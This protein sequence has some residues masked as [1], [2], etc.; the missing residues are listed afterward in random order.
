MNNNYFKI[1]CRYLLRNKF[2]SFIKITGLSIG[3][4]ACMLIFLYSKDEISYDRFHEKKANLYRVSQTFQ[5]GKNS[6]QKLGITTEPLG[7]AFKKDIPEISNYIRTSGALVTLKKSTEV[8]TEHP[9]FVD[10]D[11]LSVFTF[12]LLKGDAN[13]ALK[14]INSVVLTS[15]SAKKYFGSSDVIGKTLQVKYQNEFDNFTVTGLAEDPPQNST[16]RFDLLL[17]FA[18]KKKFENTEEWFGGNLNTFLLLLPTTKVLIVEK[19][20]QAL[21]DQHTKEELGS[22]KQQQGM[23]VKITLGLQPLADIHL[24]TQLGQALDDVSNPLYSYVLIGIAVFILIIACINFINLAIAQSLKRSK[25]IGIRKVVGSSRKQLIWQFLI[26]SFVVSSVAFLIAIPL[27]QLILPFFNEL[28]NKKLS[29][30]YLSDSYLYVG[31]FLLLLI[32]SFIA[33]FYP[34]L[35]LSGFQP[36]KVLNN[37]QKLLGKGYYAKGLI[38]LQFALAIF[39]IIATIAINSQVNFLLHE[40]LGYESKNLVRINLPNNKASDKLPEIFKHELAN[41]NTILGVA[42]RNW[43]ESIQFPLTVEGKQI[44]IDYN[45]I[46]PQFFSTFK[47]PIIAGR[48]FSSDFPSDPPHAVIV[49]EN[50]VNE[51]GWNINQAVGKLIGED[52]KTVVVGVIKDYHFAPLRGKITP[53]LFSMDSN[54]NYGQ[55]WVRISPDN[56]PKTLSELQTIYKKILPFFPYDYQFMDNINA[57][58]YEVERK[59]KQILSVA[60]VL[61]IFISCLGLLGIVILSIEERTKELGIR[62]ILGAPVFSIMR[63]IMRE[64]FGLILLAFVITAPLGYY[65]VHEWLLNF[66]YHINIGWWM[67]ALAALLV[68]AI[69]LLTM[70][71]QTF[72]AARANPVKNLRTE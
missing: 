30:S 61:F 69:A 25:E 43:A 38:V 17:P 41:K 37:K 9:L 44:T 21:F 72:R 18:Y 5:F 51:A 59:W 31:Y 26:E 35:V 14:E 16:L 56:I 45:K 58:N 10:E 33:G 7:P 68:M 46:D 12:P 65:T 28:A 63:L 52:H 6:A 40:K 22:M 70:C 66:A 50:F 2:F 8:F 13:T 11:F 1:A 71:F 36:V 64:F 32:T 49:N 4:S 48:N 54:W 19:K 62:K 24:N 27:T 39:L 60:S 29:L 42:A 55:I 15:S 20:M 23:A 57:R 67:F 53:Q 47:I 34:A 3:L